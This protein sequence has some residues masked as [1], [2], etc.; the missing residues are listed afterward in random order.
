MTTKAEKRHLDRVAA[1][2]CCLCGES[3][4]QVHHVREGQGFAQRASNW[5]AVPLCQSCH[6]GPQGLHG[7]KTML[8]VM[9]MDEMDMLADTIKQL[10]GDG[11]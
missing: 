8:R 4:V 6:T 5:L 7:D 10:L 3:P 1:L 11:A 2:P 9:R